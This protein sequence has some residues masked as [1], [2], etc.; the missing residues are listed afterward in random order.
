MS[1]VLAKLTLVFVK[2]EISCALETSRFF[3]RSVS[4]S[5][6]SA[7][8]NYLITVNTACREQAIEHEIWVI[9]AIYAHIRLRNECVV[10][11]TA[12]ACYSR[13]QSVGAFIAICNRI[14]AVMAPVCIEIMRFV[15]AMI[16]FVWDRVQIVQIL[17]LWAYSAAQRAIRTLSTVRN[18][19]VTI[20]TSNLV[21]EMRSII[22]KLACVALKIIV[23]N[24]AAAS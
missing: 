13:N 6:C 24:A 23:N 18:H 3:R 2:I 10:L 17:A 19:L 14:V 7:V 15:H 16:T 11:F 21:H 1:A 8:S 9:L 12:E 20:V 4:V 5:A 22:A